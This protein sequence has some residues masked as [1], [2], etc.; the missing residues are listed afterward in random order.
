LQRFNSFEDEIFYLET[1]IH[2]LLQSGIDAKQIAVLHRTK[3][4]KI[5]LGSKLTGCG[6][7]TIETMHSQKGLEFDIVFISQINETFQ[8]GKEEEQ[9]SQEKRLIYMAMTRAREELYL[10]YSYQLSKEW[11]AIMGKLDAIK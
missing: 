8:N 1:I 4:G 9:R 7:I 10:N 6:D 11:K 3:K 5:Q 2:S